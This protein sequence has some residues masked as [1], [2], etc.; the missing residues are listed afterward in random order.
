MDTPSILLILSYGS[1]LLDLVI[2]PIPSEASTFQLCWGTDAS[3]GALGTARGRPT[4]SK[5]VVYL[6][7]SALGVMLFLV[8]LAAVARP[9][10]VA[11]LLP[12]RTLQQVEW[13]WAGILLVLMGRT[14]SLL[15]TGQLRAHQRAGELRSTGCF[16]VSRNPILVGLYL[17]YLGNCLLFS[18]LVLMIGF[19]P[20]VLSM[21]R[22]V[23]LEED[24]LSRSLG[25]A[26]LRYS[27]RV[28]R[29]LLF[30]SRARNLD[31][32]EA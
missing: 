30:R 27:A 22:R 2:F 10:L 25:G 28:P 15:S 31:S 32:A 17:F 4:F 6:L 1:F 24:N 8:P 20:Y 16:A 29:Y 14:L 5:V 11:Y 12:V 18:S 26:Y 21:H 23:L 19:V 7:P 13:R 9:D 3:A